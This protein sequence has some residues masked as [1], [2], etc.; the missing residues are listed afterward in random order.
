MRLFCRSFVP[1]T[2]FKFN[3]KKINSKFYSKVAFTAQKLSVLVFAVGSSYQCVQS[4]SIGDFGTQI[5]LPVSS[6]AK[7]QKRP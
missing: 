3:G 5:E 2:L 7:R 4:I 1:V 6:L